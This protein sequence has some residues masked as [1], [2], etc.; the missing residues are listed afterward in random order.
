MTKRI[1][2]VDTNTRHMLK[3]QFN[4]IGDLAKNIQNV[5]KLIEEDKKARKACSVDERG[6]VELST[7]AI[8]DQK[9]KM[10]ILNAVNAHYSN[11]KLT[12]ENI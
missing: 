1:D 12:M 2:H 5:D 10:Q 6:S 3:Y 4:R 9:N 8:I 11:E 7:Q